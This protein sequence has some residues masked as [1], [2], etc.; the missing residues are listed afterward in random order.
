MRPLQIEEFVWETRPVS[1]NLDVHPCFAKGREHDFP[2]YVLERV[3][4][5]R[6]VRVVRNVWDEGEVVIRVT[7]AD[8]ES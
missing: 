5:L 6:E 1:K 2:N 7:R 4:S 3:P 8:S